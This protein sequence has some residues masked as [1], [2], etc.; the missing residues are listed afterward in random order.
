MKIFVDFG[1]IWSNMEINDGK[2]T[3]MEFDMVAEFT[4]TKDVTIDGAGRFKLPAIFRRVFDENAF[5]S[6]IVVTL[7]NAENSVYLLVV[8]HRNWKKILAGVSA[9]SELSAKAKERIKRFLNRNSEMASLD[10]QN[11]IVLPKKLMDLAG[12]SGNEDAALVGTGN[13]VEVWNRVELD[14]KLTSP[15]EQILSDVFDI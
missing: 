5:E 4:G 9:N 12:I 10:K 6:E 15:D 11:R 7:R 8:P 2:R 14:S 13:Y 1:L 3:T